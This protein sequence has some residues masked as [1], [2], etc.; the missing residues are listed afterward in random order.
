MSDRLRRR[1]SG[2]WAV[3]FAVLVLC[4]AAPLQ[5]RTALRVIHKDLG[6][7]LQDRLAEVESLRDQGLGMRIE[8][9]CVSACTLYLGLPKTCITETAILG[10]H[11]PRTRLDGLPLPRA[12]FEHLSQQMASHYPPALRHW[13]LTKARLVT[14]SYYALTAAQAVAL[15]V[16]RCT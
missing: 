16:R 10:F 8:G 13:F 1:S 9:T 12:S 15:G 14:Q 7:D 2:L 4:A 3:S 6:G 11:G 5:A